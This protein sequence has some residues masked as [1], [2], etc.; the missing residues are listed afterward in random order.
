MVR[1]C[2]QANARRIAGIAILMSDMPQIRTLV[3][4]MIVCRIGNVGHP[5]P[6]CKIT[7]TSVERG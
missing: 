7:A 3:P 2:R 4:E 6:A 5:Y 1:V